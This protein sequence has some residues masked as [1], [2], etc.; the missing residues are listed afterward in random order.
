MLKGNA[1]LGCKY[2]MR[3]VGAKAIRRCSDTGASGRRCD[4]RVFCIAALWVGIGISEPFVLIG[5][6]QVYSCKGELWIKR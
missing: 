2:R 3:R 6:F 1:S 4:P 5:I